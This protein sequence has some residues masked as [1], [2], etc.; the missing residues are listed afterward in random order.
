MHEFI[1]IDESELIEAGINA[2]EDEKRKLC[3][4]GMNV[5]L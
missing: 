5:D 1:S 4:A 2:Y 3:M